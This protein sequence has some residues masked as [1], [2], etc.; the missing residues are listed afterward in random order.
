MNGTAAISILVILVMSRSLK[1]NANK[2]ELVITAFE[3]RY[4]NEASSI[5]V[6]LAIEVAKNSSDLK[7]FL[8]KY[9]IKIGT[10]YTTVSFVVGNVYVYISG[11][12]SLELRRGPFFVCVQ[13]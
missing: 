9:E 8:D 4:S 7:S 3:R 10:Y 11:G 6:N 5:G 13:V 1:C 2:T 12:P